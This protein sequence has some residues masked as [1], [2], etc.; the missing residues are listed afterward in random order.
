MFGIKCDL[1]NIAR[2]HHESRF[3]LW[4]HADELEGFEVPKPQTGSDEVYE[5]CQPLYDY[6]TQNVPEFSKPLRNKGQFINSQ[7]R[8]NG[9]AFV[10]IPKQGKDIHFEYIGR[11]TNNV[12]QMQHAQKL[13]DIT[14]YGGD[15][16]SAKVDCLRNDLSIEQHGDVAKAL[17][18]FIAEIDQAETQISGSEFSE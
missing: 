13:R 11:K 9:F 1:T 17:N 15:S 18:E 2:G 10:V 7:K 16:N 8:E 3:R 5:K 6:V 14:G 4:K 12:E